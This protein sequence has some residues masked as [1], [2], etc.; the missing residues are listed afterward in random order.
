MKK[1]SK[2]IMKNYNKLLGE[3][4]IRNNRMICNEAFLTS[5]IIGNLK[6]AEREIHNGEGML[7]Q[8]FTK[9]LRAKYEY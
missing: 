9:E 4:F 8:E 6:K 5:E 7:L 1:I 3:I 2:K